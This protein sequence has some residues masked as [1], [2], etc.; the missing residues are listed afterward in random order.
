MEGPRAARADELAAV[1]RLANEVFYP[2]GPIDMG[3]TFPALFREGNLQHVRIMLEAGEPVSHVGYTVNDLCIDGAVLRAACIGAVCTRESARGKNCAARIM[4][5]VTARALQEGVSLFM[6]SGG[7]GLYRRMGCVDAGLYQVY[8][9]EARQACPPAIPCETTEWTEDDLPDLMRLHQAERVRFIRD[10]G[11]MRTLLE[12]NMLC[13]RPSHTYVVRV[14]GKPCAYACCGGPDDI[15][16][17][18]VA[19]V[20]EIGGSRQA[21]LAAAPAMLEKLGAQALR[22]GLPDGDREWEFLARARALQAKPN[23]FSGTVKIIDRHGFFK[24]IEGY[25]SERLTPAESRDLRIE[26]GPTV[27]FRLGSER[28]AITEDG[29]LAALVFGSIERAVPS[30]GGRLGGI[31]GRLFPM[32][33][34]N[35]GLSYI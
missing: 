7:R 27:T 11:A 3:K 9:V 6:V 29:D 19:R 35:Y 18:G 15:T 5:D 10:A 25:V 1:V 12:A 4:D 32:P 21:V 14:D 13:C 17:A 16:G 33:L 34:P 28:L 2:T 26:C 30:A 22:I 20:E 31:L 8:Q 23:G 24:A